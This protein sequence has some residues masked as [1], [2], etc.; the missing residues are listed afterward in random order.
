MAALQTVAF[1]AAS[2]GS[3][4][5]SV[6]TAFTKD[7]ANVAVL[8]TQAALTSYASTITTAQALTN[9][10]MG[11]RVN[12]N[13]VTAGVINLPS[14]ATCAADQVTLLRNLGTTVVTLAITSGSGDTVALSKLNPGEAALVDTDGVH[15]WGVLMRGR[16]NSDNETVNG[17]CTVVGNETVGGTLTVSGA[18]NVTGNVTS[19]G[20]FRSTTANNY[21]SVTGNYG[22]FMRND[23]TLGYLMQ[24]A[25][26]DQYGSYNSLRPFFWALSTGAVTID[27][28]GAG[29][30]I[31]SRP[32]FAGKVPW[33]NGNLPRP[34]SCSS[35]SLTVAWTG[36]SGISYTV[37]STYIGYFVDTLNNATIGGNKTF[38]G[39]T[40]LAGSS[41]LQ[42]VIKAGGGGTQA[43]LGMQA[44]SGAA[45]HIVY[46]QNTFGF[47]LV[48]NANSAY[49]SLVVSVVTQTSDERLKSDIETIDSVMPKLRQLRGVYYTMDGKR[50]TGVIAQEVQKPFPELVQPL[51][52]NAEDGTPL[53][54]VNYQNMVGPLLQGLLDTDKALQ[55]ALARIEA[56]EAKQ[57]A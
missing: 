26:G 15:A 44:P 46:D 13:L 25:S 18:A 6:R 21:R 3:Q 16:T 42:T 54:G 7:N 55:A 36:G 43:L 17:N 20:E 19:S 37:D 33:D 45:G 38:T 41:T 32:T 49:V 5:D 1:G 14:A 53:L 40:T 51:G 24:T 35:N 23:G 39:V 2:D 4:G 10:H 12:I 29:V 50:S 57:A 34:V 22:V 28:T 31:G 56:L 8:Q 27:G 47:S 52:M 30:T 48:N 11:K 9:V